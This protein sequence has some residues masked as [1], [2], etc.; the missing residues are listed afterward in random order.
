MVLSGT[1]PDSPVQIV[2]EFRPNST[3]D[4]LVWEYRPS[5]FGT[6]PPSIQFHFRNVPKGPFKT[7]TGTVSFLEFDLK[8][9]VNGV[10]GVVVM[11][12]CSSP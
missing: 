8:R 6:V 3:A 4:P 10:P 9:R 12:G 11:G 2:L 7:V 5:S 1:C